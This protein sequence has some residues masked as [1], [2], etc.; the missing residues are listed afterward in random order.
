[1]SD[2][3]TNPSDSSKGPDPS[4]EGNKAPA[5]PVSPKPAPG[6]QTGANP[7]IT[8]DVEPESQNQ[9]KAETKNISKSEDISKK[10]PTGDAEKP[11][12]KPAAAKPAAAKPSISP[13]SA[14]PKPATP[15][16]TTPKS[17]APKPAAPKPANSSKPATAPDASITIDEN[18]SKKAAAPAKPKSGPKAPSKPAK[19]AKPAGTPTSAKKSASTQS[20]GKK[21]SAPAAK[22]PVKIDGA[23]SEDEIPGKAMIALD[24]VAAAV[25]VAFTVLILLDVMPFL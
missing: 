10:E 15:G 5:K 11:A 18:E 7:D 4:S 1:M 2:T 13:K 20:S 12:A 21:K 25:T 9:D 3:P 19:P 24:A 6:G 23:K 22:S 8:F 17:A 14:T 16:P